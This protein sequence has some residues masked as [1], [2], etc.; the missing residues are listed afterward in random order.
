MADEA[1]SNGDAAA[2]LVGKE[3]GE[4]AGPGTGGWSGLT[5]CPL[6]GWILRGTEHPEQGRPAHRGV[7]PG[8]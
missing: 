7:P 1:G 6:A 8:R 3:A 2:P 5:K 4:A